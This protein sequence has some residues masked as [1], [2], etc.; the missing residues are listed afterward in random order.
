M[1]GK[2][3]DRAREPIG[4]PPTPQVER[5]VVAKHE[6]HRALVVGRGC[7]RPIHPQLVS[8]QF[9]RQPQL[10]RE[11]ITGEVL[12]ATVIRGNVVRGALLDMPRAV[13]DEPVYGHGIDAPVPDISGWGGPVGLAVARR[14]VPA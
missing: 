7:A 2:A 5:E 3:M 6:W 4:T 12:T 11:W 10:V 1:V 14:V 13:A 8:V 9:A